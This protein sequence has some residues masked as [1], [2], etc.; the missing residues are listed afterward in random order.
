M[1]LNYVASLI[2]IEWS[3]IS[4][5]NAVFPI[6]FC[7]TA[8]RLT[9]YQ[10]QTNHQMIKFI[11]N[12]SLTWTRK[13]R[14]EDGELHQK[15]HNIQFFCIFLSLQTAL[16][17]SLIYFSLG[18]FHICVFWIIHQ[19]MRCL[20][21]KLVMAVSVSLSLFRYDRNHANKRKNELMHAKNIHHW[22]VFLHI[23]LHSSHH[24]VKVNRAYKNK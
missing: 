16:I 9:A 19:Q 13:K 5:S 10:G 15:S 2:W 8:S 24:F 18:A 3:P 14:R 22:L 6:I 23:T 4:H 17:T 21:Q 11:V 1:L 12:F 7:A 20:T